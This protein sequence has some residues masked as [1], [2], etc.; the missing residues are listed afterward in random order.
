MLWELGDFQQAI[1]WIIGFKDQVL[2]S[3][4]DFL[5][6]LLSD[7]AYSTINKKFYGSALEINSPIENDYQSI[8][9]DYLYYTLFAIGVIS[10]VFITYNYYDEITSGIK[11]AYDTFIS[12]LGLL[13]G[14]LRCSGGDSGPG[15]NSRSLDKVHCSGSC[16]ICNRA[17][18]IINSIETT[19]SNDSDKTIKS[20]DSFAGKGK[21]D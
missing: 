17:D 5:K 9:K 16:K 18:D 6:V 15:N 21:L 1:N 13:I 3:I 19:Y 10:V 12:L 2:I 4:I 20:I 7:E 14:Q 8:T 11:V